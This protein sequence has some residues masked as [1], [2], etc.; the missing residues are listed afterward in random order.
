M[1]IL[2][3]LAI[4]LVAVI[5]YVFLKQNRP[6]FAPIVSVGAAAMIFIYAFTCIIGELFSFREILLSFGLD[7]KYFLVG[8]K[9]LGIVCITSFAA[10]IC[11]DAG[12]SSLENKVNFAGRCA[13]FITAFPSLRS[14][15]ESVTGLLE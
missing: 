4:A 12:N 11:K 8:F 5:V 3:V 7:A 13:V 10:D 15:I 2:K 1:E 6:E 14:I 9:T